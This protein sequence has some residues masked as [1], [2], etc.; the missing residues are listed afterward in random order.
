MRRR[1]ASAP[2]L[3]RTFSERPLT[4]FDTKALKAQLLHAPKKA[5]PVVAI[6]AH[7]AQ[8]DGLPVAAPGK[9]WVG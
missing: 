1:S 3:V 8:A 4:V 9:G 2:Q 7:P 5:L 6:A